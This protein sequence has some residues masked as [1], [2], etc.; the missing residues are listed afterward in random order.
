M[1]D[2]DAGLALRP[3]DARLLCLRGMLRLGDDQP[4]AAIADFTRALSVDGNY[5]AALVNRA[6]AL[7]QNG[8][9]GSAADDLSRALEIIGDDPDLLLNRGLARAATGDVQAA[10]ADFDRALA[11]PD[12]D[13]A[14]LHFQRGACLL[15]A[16]DLDAALADLDAA[17][18]HQHRIDEIAGLLSEAGLVTE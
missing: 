9:A 10:V 6:V 18:S 7:F 2:V 4:D 17:R 14:E 16:G 15:N 5:P 12:A 1:T 11:L 13:L 8:E 3:D